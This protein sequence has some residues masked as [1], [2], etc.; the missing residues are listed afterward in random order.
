MGVRSLLIP[1]TIIV[2]LAASPLRAET[3]TSYRNERFGTIADVPA[4]W[5][6]EPPPVNGDGLAFDAPDHAARL[7]IS[8]AFNAWDSLDEGMEVYGAPPEGGTVTYKHREGRSL[9][10]SGTKGDRIFY[11]KHI[12]SCRDQVWNSA[13]LEYPA[14]RKKEFDA[15]V[16]HVAH[17]LQTSTGGQVE[18]CQ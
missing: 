17:S 8:G 15:I 16:A 10:V 6:S 9:T 4:K 7:T 2:A 1:V 5:V 12:L 13:Y 11:S 14:A 18:S 3:W